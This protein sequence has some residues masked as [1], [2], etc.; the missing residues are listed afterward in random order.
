MSLKG[1]GTDDAQSPDE[2]THAGVSSDL[3][4]PPE[5][6]APGLMRPTEQHAGVTADFTNPLV[7][8]EAGASVVSR[9]MDRA[10]LKDVVRLSQTA[11]PARE[12]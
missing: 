9:G 6:V 3:G 5:G 1:P 8:E 10:V 11:G 2:L 4:A 12:D 7:G